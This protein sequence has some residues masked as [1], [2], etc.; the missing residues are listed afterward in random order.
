MLN[1][2]PEPLALINKERTTTQ[3]SKVTLTLKDVFRPSRGFFTRIE[4]AHLAL[5]AEGIIV[6]PHQL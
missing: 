6:V 1:N 2:L 5:L 4:R 3:N